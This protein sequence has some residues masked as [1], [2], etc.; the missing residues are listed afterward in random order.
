MTYTDLIYDFDGTI[1][2]SYPIFTESFLEVLKDYGKYPTYE[3]ALALLKVSV[4]AAVDAIGIPEDMKVFHDRYKDAR[5]QMMLEKGQPMEGAE[6]LLRFVKENGGRNYIYTHSPNYIW[7]LLEKWGLRS[8]FVGGV[9]ADDHFPVKP[10]PD[11]LNFICEKYHLDRATTLMVG[12]RDI[13]VDAGHNAGIKGVLLDPDG[14][15][16]AYRPDFRVNLLTEI[17]DIVI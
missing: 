9:T 6:E 16:H 4:R 2:D 14:F 1:A 8:Y 13:D 15:Y 7:T 11:A 12:D 10:A 3:E 5:H 17:K